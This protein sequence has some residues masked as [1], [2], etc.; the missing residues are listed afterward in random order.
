MGSPPL[1]LGQRSPFRCVRQLRVCGRE[2][3]GEVAS[4]G[5]DR[6]RAELAQER[7]GGLAGE[8]ADMEGF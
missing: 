4:A 2:E 8:R 6:G 5:L 3:L 7:V 1:L